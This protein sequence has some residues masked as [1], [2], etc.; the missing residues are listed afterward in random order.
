MKNITIENLV[1]NLDKPNQLEIRIPEKINNLKIINATLK[2]KILNPI[3]ASNYQ[4]KFL[5][6]LEN[7]SNNEDWLID[8][9]V[10]V[11][12]GQYV[13]INISDEFQYCLDNSITLLSLC[14]EG[15][16]TI[17]FELMAT[18]NLDYIESAEFQ[19]NGNKN[20]INLGKA[21]TSLINLVSGNMSLN[22]PLITSNNKTLPFSLNS[23][24]NSIRNDLTKNTGLP[25]KWSLNFNQFLI[26]N[27][28]LTAEDFYQDITL[29]PI[30]G[31]DTNPPNIGSP[32]EPDTNPYNTNETNSTS[33]RKSVV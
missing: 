1:L 4:I 25:N 16:K 30:E 10:N 5:S 14:F 19:G 17:E 22:T 13:S 8:Q 11:E 31:P 9:L 27:N 21:G 7:L 29:P 33:D 3:T 18:L 12:R 23:N 2:V 6:S 24:Y 32:E 28:P 20:E 26:K 15:N